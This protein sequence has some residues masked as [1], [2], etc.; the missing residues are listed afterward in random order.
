MAMPTVPPWLAWWLVELSK[1]IKEVPGTEASGRI[2]SYHNHTT[3]KATSDEVAWC[4]AAM[5]CCFDELGLA[6]T[7]SAAAR[8]WLGYGVKLKAFKLGA[9]AVFERGPTESLAGHVAIA[10]SEDNNL[11]QVIGGNQ[12]NAISIAKFPKSKL[13][14]YMW[15]EGWPE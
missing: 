10:L 9:I 7:R 13:I 14:A 6:S 5:C 2:I 12:G 1:N 11:V 4:S 8:S 3:L 15:P